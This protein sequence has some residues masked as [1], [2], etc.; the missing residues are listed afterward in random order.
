MPNEQTS[1]P[2]FA[3][4]EVLTAS[5]LN[6]SAGT[7]VPVFATTTT[8]DAAFGGSGEKVLAEGQLCYLSSTNVTQQ[9]N[10]ASWETVGPTT[11]AGLT[12]VSSTTIGSAVASVTISNAF[13]A[14]Y[15]NY[16][17]VISNSDSSSGGSPLTLV[18]VG[19][20]ANYNGTTRY[21]Y[22]DGSTGSVQR[23]TQASAYL[24]ATGDQNETS[25]SFDIFQPNL[26]AYTTWAGTAF[27][28]ND[29][30]LFGG[31]HKVATAYTD[32]TIGITAGT[33]TGGTIKV[34][35]YSN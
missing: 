27:A 18:L 26:A 23:I 6:I 7:G 20:T 11:S 2:L 32:L 3:S 8:R 28:S 34:Y 15:V 4:G 25:C 22:T 9:Y 24:S 29:L 5:N 16:R 12:L 1:V 14:T 35:G 17:I 19:S 10:G 30:S 21:F 33:L 31:V 13:S